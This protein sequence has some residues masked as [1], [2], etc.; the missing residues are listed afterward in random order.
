M[1]GEKGSFRA[2][3]T[4][5]GTHFPSVHLG[6]FAETSLAAPAL[7]AAVSLKSPALQL[8][9]WVMRSSRPAGLG[10]EAVAAMRR[11]LARTWGRIY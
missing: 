4:W 1:K 3:S 8:H 9:K 10:M 11:G 2:A 5:L 6:R 7:C